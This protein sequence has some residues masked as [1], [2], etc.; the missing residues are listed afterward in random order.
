MNIDKPTVPQVAPMVRALY[1]RS[2]AGCCLHVVLDDQNIDDKSVQ[3]C[4]TYAQ[5]KG[6]QECESLARI[7]LRMSKTQRL[8]LATGK[9]PPAPVQ[10]T[11]WKLSFTFGPRHRED[12]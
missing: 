7:L 5:E 9:L 6:H 2:G 11:L 12:R 10:P 1:E 8:K 3:F 4:V